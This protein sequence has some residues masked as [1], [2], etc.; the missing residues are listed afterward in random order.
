MT[1]DRVLKLFLVA[2]VLV[3]AWYAGR[4]AAPG[5]AITVAT[6]GLAA[7]FWRPVLGI[8]VALAMAA[9]AVYVPGVAI[10]ALVLVVL[11]AIIAAFVNAALK[12]AALGRAP[13]RRASVSPAD[14]LLYFGSSV[15]GGGFDGGGCERRRLLARGRAFGDRHIW[16]SRSSA[17]ASR[18]RHA[19]RWP[20]TGRLPTSRG[21]SAALSTVRARRCRAGG[22]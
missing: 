5:L 14:G 9:A 11:L 8:P 20:P 18:V 6:V 17:D 15:D 12:N 13:T 1:S 2:T 19:R 10:G 16:P 4:E 21:A 3:A 22:S 7:T